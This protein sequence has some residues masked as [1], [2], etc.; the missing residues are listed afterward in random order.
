[1]WKNATFLIGLGWL[2]YGAVYF[3]YADW[4]IPVSLLMAMSTY[5]T[6]DR[7]IRAIKQKSYPWVALW[8]VG[9]WWSIDGSYWL[10]WYLVDSSALIRE[11][12]WGMS[13]CL[14]LLCGMVWTAF[15]PEKPS[16]IPP[17]LRP[18]P[19]LP[20]SAKHQTVLP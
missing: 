3:G 13:L 6:A 16:I 15:D 2:I 11:G 12:Q 14:Y 20:G 1:M 8:S 5:L 4:D 7:F 19:G 17:Q 18:D 9:A 10:Y